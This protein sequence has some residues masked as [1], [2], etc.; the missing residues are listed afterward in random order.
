LETE[1]QGAGLWRI[2]TGVREE[3]VVLRRVRHGHPSAGGR[4]PLLR[5]QQRRS[6]CVDERVAVIA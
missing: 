4:T 3:D 1:L 2:D 6:L 5:S